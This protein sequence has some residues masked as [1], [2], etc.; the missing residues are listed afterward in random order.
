MRDVALSPPKPPGPLAEE[1]PALVTGIKHCSRCRRNRSLADF[2]RSGSGHQRW[3]RAC[4]RSYL[5]A[6]GGLHLDQ[7][8]AAKLRRVADARRF[9]LE[10]LNDKSCVDCGEAD[11]VVLEFDHR[12]EK[13]DGVSALVRGGLSTKGVRAEFA[14]CD[15][16]CV[17][18]HRLRT[19]HAFG[20][21]RAR[22]DWRTPPCRLPRRERANV[23][24]VYETLEAGSCIDCGVT[25][26]CLLD[27][28]HVGEK[29]GR[30]VK[31]AT[32]GY[33][34]DRILA[35][36]AQCVVRCGNCHRRRT[37]HHLG[38]YRARSA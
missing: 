18:C 33:G 13:R 2:N 36:I 29:T 35:E 25:E 11:P 16:V 15:V 22:K 4:F 19:A 6:R 12:D 27:F 37:A 38:H 30:V 31:L 14:R 8:R 34:R 17:N 21:R 20:W 28:D 3:C 24:F 32:E 7:T 23:D 10:H 5:R 26:L 1:R 9:I